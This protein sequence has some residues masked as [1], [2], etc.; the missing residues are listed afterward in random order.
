MRDGEN[1]PDH[2]RSALRAALR[3]AL[4]VELVNIPLVALY[5]SHLPPW[6]VRNNL[7]LVLY[8]FPV[9]APF[10]LPLGSDRYRNK[11]ALLGIV[12]GIALAL[13]IVLACGFLLLLWI[14]SSMGSMH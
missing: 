1:T 2:F 4:L 8:L 5:S 14:F 12:A 6:M 11:D 9:L 3:L 13:F 7:A 10:V